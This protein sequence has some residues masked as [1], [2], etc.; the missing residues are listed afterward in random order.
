MWLYV[1]DVAWLQRN[2]NCLYTC[3]NSD[4]VIQTGRIQTV[5]VDAMMSKVESNTDFLIN[6]TYLECCV[7]IINI[8]IL[9]CFCGVIIF[10][11]FVK[12]YSFRQWEQTLW[13]KK[14]S[15][16]ELCWVEMVFN[17]CLRAWY[18]QGTWIKKAF[19]ERGNLCFSR[20]HAILNSCS[21]AMNVNI[22]TKLE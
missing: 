7:L 20:F 5:A 21:I 9:V 2:P 15:S 1:W 8:I 22:C 19:S 13:N 11:K 16:S 18:R 14:W 12:S 10:I 17:F 6:R 3:I 4:D